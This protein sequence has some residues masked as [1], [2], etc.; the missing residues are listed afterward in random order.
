MG[1]GARC[2]GALVCLAVPAVAR[3]QLAPVGAPPG[4]LRFELDGAFD[5]W[6]KRFRDGRQR[7]PRGV[8]HQPALGQRPAPA[9]DLRRDPAARHRPRHRSTQSRRAHDRR[10][11]RRRDRDPG[12]HPRRHPQH[13][14]VRPPPAV[15]R[16]GPERH[17]SRR[18]R[19]RRL[20]S[21][22][23]RAG[24]LLRPVRRGADHAADP[25][26]GR[27]LRWRS[28]APRPRGCD[29][30]RRRRPLR[31]PVHPARRPRHRVG[32]D[33]DRGERGGDRHRLPGLHPPDHAGEQPGRRWVLDRPRSPHRDDRRRRAGSA[34][35]RSERSV[36]DSDR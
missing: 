9:R 31:R 26:R 14:R 35:E 11:G 29:A 30:G 7:G 20:Q 3:A 13:R 5:S 32:P 16:A 33:T 21:R 18:R 23:L 12:P 2:L 8:L 10:A 15:A 28:R 6:D 36:R 24:P 27:H 22:Y 19:Q 34:A 4:V 17:R 1:Y 25:D